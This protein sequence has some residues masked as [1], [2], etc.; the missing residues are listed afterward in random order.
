MAAAISAGVPA[1]K[2]GHLASRVQAVDAAHD[3]RHPRVKTGSQTRGAEQRTCLGLQLDCGPRGDP[4]PSA[5]TVVS[6]GG[7]YQP[8]QS[9][10]VRVQRVSKSL[11]VCHSFKSVGVIDI[12]QNKLRLT[13]WW[14]STTQTCVF[15]EAEQYGA[16]APNW[17]PSRSA[18][19][20]MS[21]N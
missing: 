12:V 7:R 11:T 20:R 1:S 8:L 3:P 18:R 15:V 5:C 9:R 6:P 19:Q 13:C 17:Q 16:A 21:D 4:A 14:H 10:P 2:A